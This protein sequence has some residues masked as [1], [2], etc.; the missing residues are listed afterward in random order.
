MS[1]I[2]Q[3]AQDSWAEDEAYSLICRYN[4]RKENEWEADE[5][6]ESLRADIAHMHK[7]FAVESDGAELIARFDKYLA[8]NL[9]K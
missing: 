5:L 3:E 2:F 1:R 9:V 4:R 7:V 6:E 8:V